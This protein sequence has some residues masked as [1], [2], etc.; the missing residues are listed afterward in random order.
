MART[1]AELT[2][3]ANLFRAARSPTTVAILLA[4][5]DDERSSGNL[6]DATGTVVSHASTL[7]TKLRLIG[8]IARGREGPHVVYSLTETGRAVVALAELAT[9]WK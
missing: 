3:V 1:R 9:M 6:V 8:L 7:L 4:L 2:R 5:G